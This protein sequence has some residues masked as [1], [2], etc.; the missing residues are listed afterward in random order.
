M[1]ASPGWGRRIR[2]P[3]RGALGFAPDGTRVAIARGRTLSIAAIDG[4]GEHVVLRIP[5]GESLGVPTWSS[6][7]AEIF[8]EQT[9]D[10]FLA[11]PVAGGAARVIKAGQG[12]EIDIA[13][14]GMLAFQVGQFER[15]RVVLAD[16]AGTNRVRLGRGSSPVFSPD[17]SQLAFARGARIFITPVDAPA[18]V[19]LLDVPSRKLPSGDPVYAYPAA[20]TD[21][22]WSPDGQQL[23]FV[24]T[25]DDNR[26][27]S[28]LWTVD[29][30]DPTAPRRILGAAPI[31]A[32][33]MF[34]LDWQ[35]LPAG[36]P[37][38]LP[39]FPVPT[40]SCQL[41]GSL[42]VARTRRARVLRDNNRFWG[43]LFTRN[44][45]WPFYRV[46]HVNGDASYGHVAL[47]GPYVAYAALY[48]S[49]V[50]GPWAYVVVQDLRTGRFLRRVSAS[51]LDSP[52]GEEV[53][54]LALSRRGAVAWVVRAYDARARR[55][56]L[57][58]HAIGRDGNRARLDTGNAIRPRS[59]QWHGSRLTWRHGER[60]R[61]RFLRGR[62]RGS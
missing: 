53:R 59:L 2:F 62:N 43:C 23:A 27:R 38:V 47:A 54:R 48:D 1:D 13:P 49:G 5:R 45:R 15:A 20:I 58:L 3:K 35:P 22:A 9:F 51:T 52:E 29:L 55:R 18:P 57:Q 30:A 10:G 44:Q 50:A 21:V 60:A 4:G 40:G 61:S 6:D 41:E 26:G 32:D 31:D 16:S 39:E 36:Q 34:G 25:G 14:G 12:S 46:R 7:G 42:T 8:V 19:E 11:V 28:R 56:P 17:G 24:R 37:L 33:L